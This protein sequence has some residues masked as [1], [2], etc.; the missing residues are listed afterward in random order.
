M[1]DLTIVGAGPAGMTAAVYSARKK[2]E[3]TLITEIIGGQMTLTWDIENYMGYQFI[4]GP[5]L[6]SKF[7]KQTEQFP[8]DVVFDTVA[9][10]ELINGNF[11]CITA[12]G[13]KFDSW[14]LLICTGKRSRELGVPGE[15]EFR[16]RGVSYCAICDAPLYRDVPV[17]VV[18]CGNSGIEAAESVS[19][20]ASDVHVVCPVPWMADPI[21][22]EKV[23]KYPGIKEYTGYLV[24]KI[25][26]DQVVQ[27]IVVR[28]TNSGEDRT[29]K[30]SGVF[31]EIGLIPNS[32]FC[33]NVMELNKWGEIVV[34]NRN[35]TSVRGIFAA[36]DVTDVPEKQIIIAAG[37]GAK[38]ALSAYR[39]LLT[40]K[41]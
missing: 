11:R 24:N 32:E 9:R 26:G 3:T 14:A 20:Y 22:I 15:K 25:T 10:I 41:K 39:Y 33:K 35:E 27:E 4:S 28:N 23:R 1:K 34:N 29:L 6:T 7:E 12:S 17:A 16:G 31:I 13:K 2:L 40:I 8:V 36:G 5:E 30:V 21:L 37:E 38:A 19:K 18:G